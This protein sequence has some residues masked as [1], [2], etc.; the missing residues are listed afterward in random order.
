MYHKLKLRVC[1]SASA[2]CTAIRAVLHNVNIYIVE[3]T[4]GERG[5]VVR[6]YSRTAP[7]QRI[8]RGPPLVQQGQHRRVGLHQ[9]R[10]QELQEGVPQSWHRL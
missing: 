5:P 3:R 6:F 1:V 2:S 4:G 8:N 9:G 7:F 10:R